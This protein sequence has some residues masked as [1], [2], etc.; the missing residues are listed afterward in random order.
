VVLR[1]D[2]VGGFGDRSGK[3]HFGLDRWLYLMFAHYPY[4]I[5]R[6]IRLRQ[7]TLKI[8]AAPDGAGAF[9]INHMQLYTIPILL[10]HGHDH[11]GLNELFTFLHGR[12]KK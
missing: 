2:T 3:V 7:F 6:I 9:A 12:G 1:P 4:M 10:M 5:D 11:G 8:E